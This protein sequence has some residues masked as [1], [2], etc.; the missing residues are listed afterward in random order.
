MIQSKALKTALVSFLVLVSLDGIISEREGRNLRE[1]G[2][3]TLEDLPIIHTF[4]ESLS[5][6]QGDKQ[7]DPPMLKVWKDEWA[8]A[9]FKTN[10]LNLSDARKHPYFK[11][12]EPVVEELFPDDIYNRFCFYR[13]LA[14]AWNGGGWMSDIDTY[15]TNFPIDE[16]LNL[17]NEG[18]F[19][20]FQ[21]FVPSLISASGDEW[22]RVAKLMIE[23]IPT[24]KQ[25]FKSD[26]M[27]LYDLMTQDSHDIDFKW[28][29]FEFVSKPHDIL[30]NK[31][32]IDCKRSGKGRAIHMSHFSMAKI[33]GAG[34][35][36]VKTGHKN[37]IYENDR[38]AGAKA[39]M[40]KWRESCRGSNISEK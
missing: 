24:S 33:F 9:G 37:V 18:K 19:T 40:D 12:M 21:G 11:T 17:P 7:A 36:P 38:A 5:S 25:S 2:K 10:I 23:D 14:M 29:G 39:L 15:P 6:Q 22:E 13:Y 27:I 20:S 16:G 30:T 3:D 32:D 1:N 28:A 4:Y 35:Y 31:G 8:A 34:L 26:M